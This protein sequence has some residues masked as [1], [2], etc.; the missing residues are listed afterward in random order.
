MSSVFAPTS[1]TIAAASR[2]STARTPPPQSHSW[3]RPPSRPVNVPSLPFQ[4]A[5]H[6]DGRISNDARSRFCLPLHWARFYCFWFVCLS[7]SLFEFAVCTSKSLRTQHTHTRA[8][9]ERSREPRHRRQSSATA[10]RK[11][12]RFIPESSRARKTSRRTSTYAC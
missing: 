12:P 9:P 1:N 11:N 10:A 8:P 6:R 3:Q 2:D 4:C 7:S 5:A